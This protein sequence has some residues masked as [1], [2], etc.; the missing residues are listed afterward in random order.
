[1]DLKEID[2]NTWKWVDSSLELDHWRTLVNVELNL[3]VS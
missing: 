2:I 3:R 1:M